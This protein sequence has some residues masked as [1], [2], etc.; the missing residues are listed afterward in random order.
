MQGDESN[1]PPTAARESLSCP[2]CGQLTDSLKRYHF[3]KWFV[4]LL[5]FA[6]WKPVVHIACPACMRKRLWRT[7][8]LN[9]VPINLLLSAVWL[10]MVK[11]A[12]TPWHFF[13]ANLLLVFGF[14][15][16]TVVLSIASFRHGHSKSLLA[17]SPQAAGPPPRIV[18]VKS[19][20]VLT[21]LF[22]VFLIAGVFGFVYWLTT[23]GHK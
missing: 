14:L 15:P 19:S 18:E 9:I 12:L 2:D 3:V 4:I 17:P 1:E 11:A 21:L 23:L 16:A 8:L 6:I 20:R 13:L 10:T 7:S 22:W 5:A